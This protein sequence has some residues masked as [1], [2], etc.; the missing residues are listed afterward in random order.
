VKARTCYQAA[1]RSQ[2]TVAMVKKGQV[3]NFG[4]RAMKAQATFVAGLFAVAA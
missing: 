3:H 1:I 4:G 2:P